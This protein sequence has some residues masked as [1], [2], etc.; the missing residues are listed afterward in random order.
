M[1]RIHSAALI[2]IAAVSGC[3]NMPTNASADPPGSMRIEFR[4]V[5]GAQPFNCA[6]QY[7]NVG[8]SRATVTGA[9]FR[10]Y[11]HDVQ[12]VR[13][14]GTRA[15]FELVDDG[16]FQGQGVA[17]LD[18]EDGTGGCETGSPET[19]THLLGRAPAGD[20][21]GVAF[22]LGV[23]QA[24]NHLNAPT[25]LAPLNIP[26]LWWSWSGGYKFARIEV[27]TAR[28]P[29]F[30]F[31]L[32]A[33]GC[34]GNVGA[35]FTCNYG[36]RGE[37]QINGVDFARDAVRVDLAALL[38]NVD[39]DRTPDGMADRIAGCMAFAGDPECPAMFGAV[40]MAFTDQ[41]MV[42]TQTMFATMPRTP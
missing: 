5:V 4:A 10:L 39:V 28:N 21:T 17:L 16:R 2:A 26:G 30:Y 29:F 32:G 13:R 40:G 34:M 1:N 36:N 9:D 23:P 41:P 18:F 35:G 22:K 7:S 25:A 27:R 37:I 19:R 33:T 3:A 42:G 24:L 31:H 8:T 20:Y 15:P 11:V 6:T 14:D 38:A 12:L